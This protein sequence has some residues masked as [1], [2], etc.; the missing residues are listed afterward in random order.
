MISSHQASKKS[1]FEKNEDS[2]KPENILAKP[3][4]NIFSSE[5]DSHEVR[6]NASDKT[7]RT[8]NKVI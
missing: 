3:K 8:E 2:P 5:F 7:E 1:L 4:S 6:T